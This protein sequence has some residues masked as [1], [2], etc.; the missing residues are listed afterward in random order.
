MTEQQKVLKEL[1]DFYYDNFKNL[2]KN[3]N[4]ELECR[5]G[6]KKD[7]SLKIMKLDFDNVINKLSSLGFKPENS[8]NISL[9]INS[10]NVPRIMKNIR[11]EIN[12]IDNIQKYCRTNSIVDENGDLKNNIIFVNKN[13]LKKNN[14]DYRVDYDNFN[15]RVD[16]SEEVTLDVNNEMVRD[17]IIN[18]RDRKKWFRYITRYTFV[19]ENMPFKVDCSIVKT[20]KIIN[21]RMINEYNILDTN[22]F[23]NEEKFEIE[24]EYSKLSDSIKSELKTKED[25]VNKIILLLKRQILIVLMGLQKTNYPVCYD[26]IEWIEEEYLKLINDDDTYDKEKTQKD[27]IGPSTVTLQMENLLESNE[28]TKI[29]SIRDNYTVTEKADGLRKLLFIAKTGRIYFIDQNMNIQFTGS[30]VM[31]KDL[32]NTICDG[33]HVTI[34]INNNYKNRFLIFDIYIYNNVVCRN[35]PLIKMKGIKEGSRLEKMNDFMKK[36]S[37]NIKSITN[38]EATIDIELKNFRYSSDNDDTTIFEHSKIILDNINNKLL[39]YNTDGLI[40]TPM[41]KA[42]GSNEI[43][44]GPKKLKKSTWRSSFKWKPAEFNTVDFLI[45]S[46]KNEDNTELIKTEINEGIDMDGSVLLEYKKFRLRVGYNERDHG[47][48][49]PCQMLLDGEIPESSVED[50]TNNYKPML[51]YPTEPSSDKANVV[52]IKIDNNIK[53]SGER[54][55]KAENGDII[56]DKMIVEFSYN[57]EEKEGWRWKPLRVRYDKTELYRKGNKEFGNA[58]HV[59]NSV[60]QS[61]HNPITEEMISTGEN[62]VLKEKEDVYYLKNS[63]KSN[64]T[65][66]RNFH[67]SYVKRRL[68]LSASNKGDTLI[69][70]AVGKGGDISKWKSSNLSFV[71][72]IDKSSDNIH[73]KIDGACARYLNYA[74]KGERMP[75]A[76]FLVGDSGENLKSGKG[77]Y[78]DKNK[79]IMNALIG[80][81]IKD[82]SQLGINVYKQYGRFTEG[83]NIVSCQFAIHYFFENQNTIFNFIKNVGELCDKNGYFI[84]TSYDGRTIFNK[85]KQLKKGE[86]ISGFKQVESNDPT[87]IKKEKIWEI[88]KLYDYIEF[89]N[90]ISSLGYPI[91]VY[92][93]SIGKSFTEYLVNYEY[94]FEILEKCG[95]VLLNK[96]EANDLGLPNSTGSFRELYN[97][98]ETEIISQISDKT[99]FGKSLEM[100]PEER[101]I[102]FLNRYFILKKI[103]NVNIDEMVLFGEEDNN[104]EEEKIEKIKEEL[105]KQNKELQE[106]KEDVIG[107][108]LEIPKKKKVV[109]KVTAKKQKKTEK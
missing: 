4:M 106:N 60:W 73:N 27:F 24:L 55:C 72:G 51:F 94:L 47:F 39:P 17:L 61:I 8:P 34:D 95:F 31:N 6:T 104:K 81:G 26:E 20:S 102:S 53:V 92:Q 57:K 98:M 54:I 52:N 42:V 16:L 83:F 67:N 66:L 32:T 9:K 59:A 71:L 56:E 68:I 58:Y 64:T 13:I 11:V 97:K 87:D 89:N 62:I 5:F 109:K 48:I 108:T 44:K 35:L 85:L 50:N 29:I 43:M 3:K 37:N 69:D 21:G 70:L 93:E 36:I 86:R 77:L 1:V 15:C 23:D 33:E 90:N 14:K 41:Y 30:Q 65:P 76:L 38:K 74:K 45:T 18:W 19:H 40:Y 107:S 49:N 96:D 103:N 75:D 80:K 101:E 7:S 10:P 28:E 84:G 105:E 99:E 63:K 25:I 100:S 46:V 91:D 22:I 78:N 2:E 88:T 82:E 12:G 79:K